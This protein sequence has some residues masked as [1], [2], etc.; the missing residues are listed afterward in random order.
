MSTNSPYPPAPNDT[1]T[2]GGVA[3]GR[4]GLAITSLVL[5]I[6]GLF[7]SFYGIVGLIALILGFV[8]RRQI[9]RTGQRGSGMALAGI[10]LGA[11][12]LVWGI[13]SAVIG[14]SML[15]NMH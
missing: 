11:V 9:A 13:I 10:I 8:A 6:V 1:T 2:P 5:G 7:I 15:Q 4:N 14:F 3:T 12:G